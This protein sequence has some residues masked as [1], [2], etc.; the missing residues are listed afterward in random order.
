MKLT[1]TQR[2]FDRYSVLYVRKCILGLVPNCGLTLAREATERNGLKVRVPSKKDISIL[3][4]KSFVVRG[5]EI[6][7]ALPEDLRNFEGSMESF[8]SRLDSFL[9]LVEDSPR[10]DNSC[11]V[12]NSLDKRIK[13]WTWKLGI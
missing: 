13:E 11:L 10:I 7:N 1:S 3:R 2:R 4:S 9:E 5:P 6:F 12:D 8:K